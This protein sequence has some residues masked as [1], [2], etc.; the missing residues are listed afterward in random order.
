[1]V[2]IYH[3]FKKRSNVFSI[4]KKLQKMNDFFSMLNLN[5]YILRSFASGIYF[6][7]KALMIKPL[8]VSV[9]I[10]LISVN[11]CFLF[12]TFPL[13]NPEKG[14]E[15]TTFGK[16]QNLSFIPVFCIINI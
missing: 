5:Y 3:F 14:C 2:E 8:S 6:F 10:R 7:K 15:L 1:M 16:Y 4:L 11:P 13:F 12:I 9:E